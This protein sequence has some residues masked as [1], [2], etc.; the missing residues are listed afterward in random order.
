MCAD[1]FD[2]HP[3]NTSFYHPEPCQN[4]SIYCT[5]ANIADITAVAVWQRGYKVHANIDNIAK[6]GA[7]IANIAK[8]AVWQ[9]GSV[10]TKYGT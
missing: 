9:R 7:N 1:R 4:L 2:I 10:A 6:M 5:G 3:P 8:M